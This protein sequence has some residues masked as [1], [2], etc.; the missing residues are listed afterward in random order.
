MSPRTL[1][2]APDLSTFFTP[3][4]DA[5]LGAGRGEGVR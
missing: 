3:R 5:A 2:A 1:T 4:E